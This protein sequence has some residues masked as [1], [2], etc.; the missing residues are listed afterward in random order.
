MND[1][2]DKGNGETIVHS[3]HEIIFQFLFRK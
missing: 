2:L 3:R 1:I